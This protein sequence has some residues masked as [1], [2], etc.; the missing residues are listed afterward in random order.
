MKT[1]LDPRE[2]IR[3]RMLESFIDEIEQF[4]RALA[5]LDVDR[6]AKVFG[7]GDRTDLVVWRLARAEATVN[8]TR[9]KDSVVGNRHSERSVLGFVWLT[10]ARQP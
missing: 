3:H 1:L 2:K 4:R 8:W 10:I 6:N 7:A 9:F 5:A